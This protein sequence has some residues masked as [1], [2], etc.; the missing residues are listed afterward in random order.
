VPSSRLLSAWKTDVGE[1]IYDVID[2]EFSHFL[3]TVCTPRRL[4]PT[5]AAAAAGSVAAAAVFDFPSSSL[6]RDDLTASARR[7]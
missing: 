6:V 4:E 7:C 5:A 2:K 3:P 1:S